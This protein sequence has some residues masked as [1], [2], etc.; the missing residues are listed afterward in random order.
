[1]NSD[2]INSLFDSISNTFGESIEYIYKEGGRESISGIY[3]SEF[4]A[5]DSDSGAE[6]VSDSPVYEISL[7]DIT[8]YPL[9]GDR[10]ETGDKT[11]LIIKVVSLDQVLAKLF[12]REVE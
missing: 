10:I 12:I 7:S 8:R 2:Q 11:Y 9:D 1:M 3:S 5:L 6:I 4:R